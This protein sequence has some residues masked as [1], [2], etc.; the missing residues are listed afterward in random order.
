MIHLKCGCVIKTENGFTKVDFCNEGF[1]LSLAVDKA[2]LASRP[3]S[4]SE[5]YHRARE[6]YLA[7]VLQGPI[8][9]GR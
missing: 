4:L 9:E 1:R 7:H 2:V 8:R 3:A 5:A 6:E